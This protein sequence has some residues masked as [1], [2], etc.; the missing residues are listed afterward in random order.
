MNWN[1]QERSEYKKEEEE[2]SPNSNQNVSNEYK[3]IIFSMGQCVLFF[4]FLF[5]LIHLILSCL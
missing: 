3:S 5:E 4:S 2:L 1:K